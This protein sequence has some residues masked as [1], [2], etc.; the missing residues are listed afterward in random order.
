MLES[1]TM[2]WLALALLCMSWSSACN[3][4]K[5]ETAAP[6]SAAPV[7]PGKTGSAAITGTVRYRGPVPSTP[8]RTTTTECTHL[9]GP[10]PR[11]LSVGKDSGVKDA[12]VWI[13]DGLPPGQ[14]PVPSEP[15]TLDQ[16]GCEYTPRVLGLRVGQPIVLAN[17]DPILHNVHSPAFNVPLPNVGARVTRKFTRP[18]VMAMVTCD[19]HPW[20]RAYA[21]VVVHPFFAVTG[22]D[23][24]FAISGLP[25]GTYTVEVWQERLGRTSQQVSV[26][27][28]ES[29]RAELELKM[30]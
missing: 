15:I 23:G 22:A 28:G 14:Y 4:D 16:K 24:S 19:V 7:M 3:R 13:K 26:A 5:G 9:A 11:T 30:P 29:K 12:F 18:D 2:R 17:S 21:G 6:E 27:D 20:M 10:P 1:A 8:S 25:A